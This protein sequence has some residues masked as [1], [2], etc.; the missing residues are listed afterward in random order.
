M[1]FPMKYDHRDMMMMMMMMT[2]ARIVMVIGING[3]MSWIVAR[4]LVADD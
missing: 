4:F 1:N 3:R 2:R